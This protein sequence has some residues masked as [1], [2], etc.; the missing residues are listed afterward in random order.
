MEGQEKRANTKICEPLP[1]GETGQG[2]ACGI[3]SSS[4]CMQN[5]SF[6]DCICE[7]SQ[8]STQPSMDGHG[9]DTMPCCYPCSLLQRSLSPL[10]RLVS[11]SHC[12]I[13]SVDWCSWVLSSCMFSSQEPVHR[14]CSRGT[15]ETPL[16]GIAHLISLSWGIPCRPL[17]QVRSNLR[18]DALLVQKNPIC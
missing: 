8:W 9:L 13:T 4:S 15:T 12:S 5:A 14:E 10:P 16:Y 2:T 1:L 17:C 18:G 3:W 11:P 7:H 6:D